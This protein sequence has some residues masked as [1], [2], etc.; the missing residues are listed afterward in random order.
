MKSA[1]PDGNALFG[2]EKYHIDGIRVERR[3]LDAL[4]DT[5]A[6]REWV[7]TFSAAGEPRGVVS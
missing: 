6:S 1:F 3:R 2:L 4:L 5:P 7:P